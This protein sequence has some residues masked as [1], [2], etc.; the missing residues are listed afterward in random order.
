MSKMDQIGCEVIV[1]MAVAVLCLCVCVAVVG[2]KA[3]GG[4]NVEYSE[5]TRSGIIQKVSKKGLIWHTWEGELNLGYVTAIS[6]KIAPAIFR[7][8]CSNE[9][10][11]MILQEKETSGER[12][13]LE[14]TQYLLRGWKYG[15][16]QYDVTGVREN[17]R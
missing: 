9:H 2:I 8:S 6:G 12:V 17:S 10:V 14:Y 16:T 7:F 15:G 3:C 5:G 13:T 1:F 11:A 4:L